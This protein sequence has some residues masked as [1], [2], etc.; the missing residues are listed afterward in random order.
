MSSTESPAA[1][2]TS[3]IRRRR[4]VFAAIVVAVVAL[5]LALAHFLSKE[6]PA[7]IEAVR[8]YPNLTITLPVIFTHAGDGT[9]RIFV[10]SQRGAIHVFPNDQDVE[11]TTV[12]LDIE[13][14]VTCQGEEGLLGLAFHPSYRDNGEFFVYYTPAAV[15]NTSVISR[16]HVL[17]DD[18]D[19]ADPTSEE[20][21]MR[22]TRPHGFHCGGALA[23][24][25]DGYLYVAVG[26]GGGGDGQD[27]TT[28]LGAILRIDVDRAEVGNNYAIPADNPFVDRKSARPEIWAYGLRNVWRMSFDRRTDALWAADVGEDDWEEVDLIVRGGNYGWSLREGKHPFGPTGCGPRGDLIEPVWEYGH[29]VGHCVIGGNVYRGQKIPALRGAYLCGDYVNNKA[30][31]LRRDEKSGKIVSVAAIDR[32]ENMPIMTFGEDEQGEVYC[33]DA[34]GRIFALAQAE[35]P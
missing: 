3:A 11:Q 21:I 20:E 30:W 6:T 22:I 4:W 34:F 10:G 5:G 28:L 35:V 32:I 17:P 9:D 8:A 2:R 25:P 12:F 23:F 33:T 31:M 15:A 7:S 18:P 19:R 1:D 27:L 29:G 13:H 24:G 16:F 14:R 26:D